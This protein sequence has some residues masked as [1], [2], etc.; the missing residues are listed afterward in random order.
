MCL[1]TSSPTSPACG[2]KRLDT[3]SSMASA[4]SSFC[5]LPISCS[6]KSAC[7]PAVAAL[8]SARN[9]T[10]LSLDFRAFRRRRASATDRPPPSVSDVSPF[11]RAT[12]SLSCADAADELVAACSA[13][14]VVVVAVLVVA[15]SAFESSLL[16]SARCLNCL[17]FLL[18]RNTTCGSV[19]VSAGGASMMSW[20]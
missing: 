13:V 12:A 16:S 4:I 3:P 5:C 8:L 18:G 19:F 9:S 11:S 2:A 20:E 10:P 14:V 1:L 7:S 17:R 15:D 6:L